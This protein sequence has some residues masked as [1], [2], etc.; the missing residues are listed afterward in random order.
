MRAFAPLFSPRVWCH[1]QVLMVGAFLPLPPAQILA[2]FI[3]RWPLEVTFAEA[4]R[5]LGLEAQRRS[6]AAIRR[7]TQILLGL[8]SLV[9]L[10]AHRQLAGP[11]A[12][13]RQATCLGNNG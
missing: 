7:T 3:Q 8:F 1:A 5:H 12:V 2:W 11:G 13:G 10:V 4:R 6:E 9:T